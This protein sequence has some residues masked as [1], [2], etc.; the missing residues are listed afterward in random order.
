MLIVPNSDSMNT[1]TNLSHSEL[2]VHLSDILVNKPY[3]LEA[4]VIREAFDYHDI[5]DF[6]ADLL[7]HG[8]ISGMVGSLIYYSDTHGFYDKHYSE[9]E[10]MREDY[11]GSVG[12]PITITGDL[13]NFMAWFA[14]EE[15]AYQLASQIGLEI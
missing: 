15:T 2:K 4:A 11:E 13:K 5:A 1:I 10:L 9:I 14:F 3:G 12:A 7:Q 6:F 8:C